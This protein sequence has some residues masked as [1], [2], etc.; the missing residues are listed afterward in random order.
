[1]KLGGKLGY[2]ESEVGWIPD[3][4][5]CEQLA[6]HINLLTGA[7]FKSEL[8]SSNEGVPLIRIRDLLRGFSE[9]G[10]VGEYDERYVVSTGDVLVGM[11]G[12]FHVV[13]WKGGRAL[14]NQRVLRISERPGISDKGFLFYL[15]AAAIGQIQDGISATTVKHLSTKD[16]QSLT[17]AIPPLLEQH[18]IA[19]ILTAVDVK[20]DVIARQIEATQTL[21]QGL[22]Q[23]L[24]SRGAGV[25]SASGAW[26]P[27][28]QFKEGPIGTVPQCWE[29]CT[30]GDLAVE[31]I[32]YGVVQPGEAVVDGVQMVRGGDIKDGEIAQ[33]LRT[34]SSE[35]SSQ[36]KR[37]ILEGGEL[38]VSL[39]GYPGETAV[40]PAALKG[41]NIARQAGMIRT[42]SLTLSKYLHCYLASPA[43]KA[44]LLG[45][46][47][48]S[49]QQVINLKSLRDVQ[50]PMP[51]EAER[52]QITAV[53]EATSS[54][55]RTLSAK[56]RSYGL[57]K[58][59]LMQKLLTGEWR[60]K[61]DAE[62]AV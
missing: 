25:Q 35:V 13:R 2:K 56:Q 44:E 40:V 28:E 27:H 18:K 8:F 37:T 30:L 49:A 54:K 46:M 17:A 34:I 50:V 48:G 53:C 12:E 52:D 51:P 43:G 4:W 41:A 11:D 62:M 36:F 10:Y 3:D 14:L 55:L 47:I 45:G 33:N 31:N 21:K 29:F 5:R 39:V 19:A 7:P 32:T 57:L 59:G 38:L 24:F 58:R 42:G 26:H 1:M 20:L 9:T 61:V 16:L 15:V 22:M 6:G 60:V 23:T